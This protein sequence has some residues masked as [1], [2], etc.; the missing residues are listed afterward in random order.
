MQPRGVD[1]SGWGA[2]VAIGR[3]MRAARVAQDMHREVLAAI[4]ILELPTAAHLTGALCLNSVAC[5]C[6]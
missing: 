2:D 4:V 1:L 5:V 6:V 3:C